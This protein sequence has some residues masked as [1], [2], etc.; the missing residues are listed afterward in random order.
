MHFLSSGS[1]PCASHVRTMKVVSLPGPHFICLQKLVVLSTSDNGK[2]CMKKER[3]GSSSVNN[4]FLVHLLVTEIMLNLFNLLCE[5]SGY[6]I[7]VLW[8]LVKIKTK[9]LSFILFTV[10]KVSRFYRFLY[11]VNRSTLTRRNTSRTRL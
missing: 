8:L 4:S 2:I 11:S 1:P 7:L 10:S 3:L 9:T 6:L 5:V